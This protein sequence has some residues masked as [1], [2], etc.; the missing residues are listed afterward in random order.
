VPAPLI[1]VSKW[2]PLSTILIVTV[3]VIALTLNVLLDLSLPLLSP[4]LFFL[5]ITI[6]LGYSAL[7]VLFS[8]IATHSNIGSLLLPLVLTPLLFPLFLAAI[9]HTATILSGGNSSFW[10][11]FAALLSFLYVL[12]GLNLY[13]FVIEE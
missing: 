3:A 10:F 1:F 4:S 11:S 2:L 6:A 7:A 8:P 12:L 5:A 13:Q 9:E